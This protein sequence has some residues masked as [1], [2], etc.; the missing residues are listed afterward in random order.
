MNK[1]YFAMRLMR[2]MEARAW[3]AAAAREAVSITF[4]SGILMWLFVTELTHAQSTIQIGF[5][6]PPILRPGAGIHLQEYVESG[7]WFRPIPV[8]DGFGRRFAGDPRDPDNGSLAYLQ[9]LSLI[10]I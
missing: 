10:H 4:S 5:E 7:V 3:L 6:L 9:G 8:T 1:G 2:V